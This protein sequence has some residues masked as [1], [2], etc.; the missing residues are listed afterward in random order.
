MGKY[1]KNSLKD[2]SRNYRE[3]G[4]RITIPK[5]FCFEEDCD[6]SAVVFVNSIH[7]TFIPFLYELSLLHIFR[8]TNSKYTNTD[9]KC[10]MS[11]LYNMM[12]VTSLSLYNQQDT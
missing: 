2:F 3:L 5:Y 6:L 7:K 4:S 9:N 1:P 11:S 10:D 12:K 8:N